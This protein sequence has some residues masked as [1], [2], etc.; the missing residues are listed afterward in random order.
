MRPSLLTRTAKTTNPIIIR[1]SYA[2]IS[3]KLCP[4]YSILR[5]A[6]FSGDLRLLQRAH[7]RILTSGCSADRLL[8]N[9][10]ISGYSKCD[11]IA[12]ARRTFEASP[13]RDI[14]SFNSLLSAFALHDLPEDGFHLF[15]RMASPTALSFAP[16]LKLCSSSLAFSP[17]GSILHARAFKHGLQSDS[18]VS[19]ALVGFYVKSGRAER[20]RRLFDVM[21]DRDRILYNVMIKAYSEEGLADEA[22]SALAEL[23]RDGILPC[24]RT[25]H[26]L[27]A[28]GQ[29]G[30]HG[31]QLQALGF[32][33][34]L[35]NRPKGD[36]LV[37]NR[38]LSAHLKAGDDSSVVRKFIDMRNSG[39]DC[40]HVT[41]V[42]LTTSIAGIQSFDLGRQSHG[43]FLKMGFL[44]TVSVSNSLINTYAKMGSSA[45]AL[46]LFDEILE[47]DLISWNS[48][49][50]CFVQQSMAE[51]SIALFLDMMRSGVRPD[52]FTFSTILRA[53]STV[54][55][56]HVQIHTAAIKAGVEGDVF[57]VTALI[58][59]Y[60]KNNSMTEANLLHAGL[61]TFDPASLNALMSGYAAGNKPILALQVF[62][63]A[64]RRG[65]IADHFTIATAMKACSGAVAYKEGAQLH[66]MAVKLGLDSDVFVCS[67]A[68]DLYIKSGDVSAGLSVFNLIPEPDDVAWTA[69]IAGSVENGNEGLALSLFQRMRQSGAVPEEFTLAAMV[70]A[71]ACLTALQK[72]QEVHAIAIKLA[73]GLDPFVAT[74]VIDMYSKCGSVEEAYQLFKRTKAEV[75]SA[76]NAIILGFAQHGDGN[77]ALDLFKEMVERGLAPDKITFIGVLSACS[78]AGLV[79][80][81][82]EFMAEMEPGFG[83]KP[84]AEHYSCMVDAL[85]RAGLLPEAVKVIEEMPFSGSAAMY[86]ALLGACRRRGERDIGDWVATR[87]L[88]LDPFDASTYVLLGNM[89]AAGGRWEAAAMARKMM[90]SRNLKKD[91]GHSWIVVKGQVHLFVADDRSHPC[92][93]AIAAKV[94]EL[95]RRIKEEGY[96]P[97]VDSVL[98]DLEMEEK[99]RALFFHSERLA[100]AFGIISLPPER[101]ITVIKNLR[102]CSDCHSAVK[103]ISLVTRR[104]ILLRD[105]NRFHR[106][107]AGRCSCG[108]YW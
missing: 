21:P 89:Y 11:S 91:P 14:V 10:L 69:M 80:R 28:G 26:H 41:A 106:F 53:S 9:N 83:I 100:I 15:S 85:G 90:S 4:W 20:A 30:R 64:L 25:F 45:S 49:I 108:D 77:R 6:A 107:V 55:R 44:S 35:L 86:R 73:H 1:S 102:V 79:Y 39:E 32:K 18:L 70:K 22:F 98:M 50:S 38:A 96:S 27:L 72:G 42:I 57:V 104:E 13:N 74:S 68:L 93:A 5:Q 63:S 19:S 31:D 29:A 8:V 16:V 36:V 40:D 52:Q 81:A 66:A 88:G 34:N 84:E 75:I 48:L 99:E 94:E 17:F 87:L 61:Q 78:H 97:E 95:M 105:A 76:W 12:G 2:T 37:F 51:P 101:T 24:E 65:L 92:S 7:A 71:C 82:R 56:L 54:H 59:A 33:L 58:D 47:R 103:L 23:H 46:N 3:S 60:C 43:L 67:S 62:F